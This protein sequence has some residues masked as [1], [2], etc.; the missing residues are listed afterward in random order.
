MPDK[1]LALAQPLSF[2]AMCDRAR[3]VMPLGYYMSGYMGKVDEVFTLTAV[4]QFG[5][6]RAQATGTKLYPVLADLRRQIKADQ[7]ITRAATAM[8]L[9]VGI[10]PESVGPFPLGPMQQVGVSPA[11]YGGIY[12][13]PGAVET[14]RNVDWLKP[15]AA[16]MRAAMDAMRED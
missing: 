8:C 2:G 16:M 4:A 13:G 6:F 15:Y 11:G 12:V 5:S 1:R 9:A 7:R 10:H 3:S 14:R